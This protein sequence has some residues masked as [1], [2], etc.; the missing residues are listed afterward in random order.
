[1]VMTGGR[2]RTPLKPSTRIYEG[3]LY[4]IVVDGKSEL[5]TPEELIDLR[6]LKFEPSVAPPEATV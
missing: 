1:M 2:V 6:D 5:G 4:R 3:R